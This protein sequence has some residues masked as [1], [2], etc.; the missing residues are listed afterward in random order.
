MGRASGT[1]QSRGGFL[2][3]ADFV[4]GQAVQLIDQLVD[5]P[6]R[7]VDPPLNLL[8]PLRRL[9][10]GEFLL[11]GAGIATTMLQSISFPTEIR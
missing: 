2:D 9:L 10:V 6:V 1:E 3:D 5:L 11:Q 7:G 8:P 4:V